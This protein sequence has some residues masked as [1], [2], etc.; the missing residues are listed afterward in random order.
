VPDRDGITMI[1]IL[2][3]VFITEQLEYAFM[4]RDFT[5]RTAECPDDPAWAPRSKIA[6]LA[7][8]G[9]IKRIGPSEWPGLV[10]VLTSK[11]ESRPPEDTP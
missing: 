5:D 6:C 10:R 9:K 2:A 7:I 11:A 1:N 3:L 4:Y 8:R